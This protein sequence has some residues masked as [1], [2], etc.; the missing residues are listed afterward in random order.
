MAQSLSTSLESCNCCPRAC[1]FNRLAGET[2]FCG[3]PAGLWVAHAGLH[4]GEEPPL[5]GTR[6]S[7][8]VFFSGCN[9][10]CVFCQNHQISQDFRLADSVLYSPSSLAEVLLQLQASGAHNVNLVSPSHMVCELPEA[11]WLAR[12]GGLSVPVVWNSGGYDSPDVLA[13]LAGLVDVY[14]P[15]LKY[16]QAE[17]ALRYSAAS[18]YPEVARA[19]L[20]AMFAQVGLLQLD[21]DGIAE[22]GLLVRHLVLPGHLENSRRC[23][24]FLAELSPEIHI[25]LMSQYSPQHLAQQHPALRRSLRVAE[26]ESIC[27]YALNLG[28]S[29]VFVQELASQQSYLPNFKCDMPFG[30]PD[31]FGGKPTSA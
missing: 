22:R 7:G 13:L 20:H 21:A 2:G 16:M 4:F 5:S 24:D 11:L 8:T 9:L 29:H 14:L 1:G 3:V 18:D 15:D 17:P 27:E 10:R 31:P 6:G 25:S 28:L 12:A 26:Y 19:A 30:P 23:L